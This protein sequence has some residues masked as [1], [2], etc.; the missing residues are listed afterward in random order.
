M[1]C[2]FKI[3]KSIET[4]ASGKF[5]IDDIIGPI[6]KE[7]NKYKEIDAGLVAAKLYAA[8]TYKENGTAIVKAIIAAETIEDVENA[9]ETD[10]AKKALLV[11]TVG[12]DVYKIK[13]ELLARSSVAVEKAKVDHGKIG[14]AT[15]TAE[16][17]NVR[18]N[19][20]KREQVSF[21]GKLVGVASFKI[22]R[23]GLTEGIKKSVEE[24]WSA[25][26]SAYFEGMSDIGMEFKVMVDDILADILVNYSAG[27]GF[28]TDINVAINELKALV[29]E[30][31]ETLPGNYSTS[32]TTLRKQLSDN[33]IKDKYFN[34]ILNEDF[35]FILETASG[36]ISV[37][38]EGHNAEKINTQVAGLFGEEID[39]SDVILMDFSALPKETMEELTQLGDFSEEGILE[40]TE[41]SDKD[42]NVIIGDSKKNRTFHRDSS[43]KMYYT[44]NLGATFEVSPKVFYGVN[45]TSDVNKSSM[46]PVVDSF[47]QDT[48]FLRN[49]FPMMR[50]INID[51][52][53]GRRLSYQDYQKIAP[54][55]LGRG[56]TLEE[57]TESL[58]EM[59]E[60][61]SALAGIA[62]SLHAHLFSQIPSEVNG[63][64]AFS[65]LSVGNVQNDN[66]VMAVAAA[67]TSKDQ[68]RYAFLEDGRIKVT[69]KAADQD[70]SYML[71][72]E[73][74]FALLD[75]LHTKDILAK[76]ITVTKNNIGV[77]IRGEGFFMAD[78]I[79]DRSTVAALADMFGLGTLY[80]KLD[81]QLM[82]KYDNVAKVDEEL[83][84]IF[85]GILEVAAANK[86]ATNSFIPEGRG[87]TEY[88]SKKFAKY[89]PGAILHNFKE[90]LIEALEP[91]V[92]K[93]QTIAG[94][95]MPSSSPTDRNA[96]LPKQ[97]KTY[98]R[99]NKYNNSV[100]TTFNPFIKSNLDTAIPYAEYKGA[101]IKSPMKVNGDPIKLSDW[102]Q[103][104]RVEFAMIQGSLKM[105]NKDN[106]G[107]TFFLQPIAY[108]DK[109]MIPMHEVSL[110]FD[111]FDPSPATRD[112][113]EKAWLTYNIN[114]NIDLQRISVEKMGRF[115]GANFTK[116]SEQLR[117]QPEITVSNELRI[118]ALKRAKIMMDKALLT[119]YDVAN[120]TKDINLELEKV[121]LTRQML[122]FSNADMDV[123][124]DYV[125]I[126]GK[127]VFKPHL[128][129][130]AEQL[131]RNGKK[132]VKTTL[133]DIRNEIR[134][135]GIKDS[136]VTSQL[137]SSGVSFTNTDEG[138]VNEFYDRVSMINGIYG[139]G[140]KVLTMGD[141]SYFDTRYD[142]SS[143]SEYYA[144]SDLSPKMAL[145]DTK[146]MMVKQSKRAQSNLTR[147]IVYMH[148]KTATGLKKDSAQDNII[149]F[150]Q[151]INKTEFDFKALEGKDIFEL[152]ALG[153]L[154][155][156]PDGTLMSADG[157]VMVNFG[158]D[159]VPMSKDI[160][161]NMF[162]DD[163]RNISAA[164]NTLISNAIT[165]SPKSAFYND[166][167]SISTSKHTTRGYIPRNSDSRRRWLT[168]SDIQRSDIALHKDRMVTVPDYIPSLLV[169][170]VESNVDL[171]NALG[172][173]QE[174][175]DA[176][177]F[178]HPVYE[179]LF[180]A[181][182]GGEISGFHSNKS[183]ALK[184]LTTT[185]EYGTFRQ[186]LQKKSVQN[187][188]GM[189]QLMKLGGPEVFG[190]LKKMNTAMRFTTTKMKVP[191]VDENGRVIYED[192]LD[193]FGDVIGRKPKGLVT[194]E[195]ENM[196]GLFDYFRG[197]ERGDDS[198][199][200]D[201]IS[202][203]QDYG[204]NMYNFIGMV[205]VPSNQKTGRR[206][207]N[208][209][210]D[211]FSDKEV[212][213]NIDHMANEFNF[214]VLTKQHEYDTSANAG[215]QAK[216]TLLSQ[217]VNAVGF[218]GLTNV[219]TQTLQNAME[220]MSEI[221][222][223][224]LGNVLANSAIEL[225]NE[226]GDPASYDKVIESLKKGNLS[227][228]TFNDA[229]KLA[230]KKTM[231]SGMYDMV[232]DA[233]DSDVDSAIIKQIL[234]DVEASLDT[235]LVRAKVL[236]SLR[237]GFYKDVIQIKMAGFI[238][239]VSV[240]HNVI[241]VYDIPGT[242]G[243][244]GG[245]QA[246]IQHVLDSKTP[247]EE[248]AL[249]DNTLDEMNIDLVLAHITPVDRVVVDGVSDAVA[250]R[251]G[252]A[253][254]LKAL[255]Q[256]GAQVG[257][258]KVPIKDA[259]LS[260]EKWAT[261]RG[262]DKV[263]ITL[264]GKTFTAHK[265]FVEEKIA[266]FNATAKAPITAEGL[267]LAE[268]LTKYTQDDHSLKW[269][270]ITA[271]NEV[272]EE[273]DAYKAAYRHSIATQKKRY[274][275]SEE[276]KDA[277]KKAED[278]SA[279]L[280]LETQKVAS[281]G[282][283]F[284][285][286]TPP[287]I[288]LP[289]YN[290][291][292]FGIPEGLSLHTI[293]GTD[294]HSLIHAKYYFK[295]QTDRRFKQEKKSEAKLDN[296]ITKYTRLR[297]LKM[298]TAGKQELTM[299]DDILTYL[300]SMPYSSSDVVDVNTGPINK[301]IDA[302]H[303]IAMTRKAEAF[304]ASLSTTLTRIPGQTKQSG[305]VG[306]VV[307]FLD[308]QGNATFA[309]TE[310][311]VNTGGDF[312]IDTLSVLTKMI[313][314]NGDMFDYSQFTDDK[315]ILS[316]K[317]VTSAYLDELKYIEKKAEDSAAEYNEKLNA[318]IGQLKQR[319]N[320]L[321]IA[322]KKGVSTAKG[323]PS[324]ADIEAKRNQ[325]EEELLA[326]QDNEIMPKE[327]EEITTKA[328]KNAY[329]R[330]MN[331]LSNAM[332]DGISTS[333]S[334]LDTAVEAQTPISMDMFAGLK[335][336]IQEMTEGDTSEMDKFKHATY[337]I[338]GESF[339]SH[340]VIED[341]AAQG[342]EAIGIYATVLK[343]NS[344][345]QTSKY[346]FDSSTQVKTINP[347]VWKT[348]ITFDSK[349]HGEQKTY[350]RTGF[351]DLDRFK[352]ATAVASDE[353][354]QNVLR[355]L[356]TSDNIYD[357]EAVAIMENMLLQEVN[358]TI[359]ALKDNGETLTPED[360][361][362]I[363]RSQI[364]NTFGIDIEQEV[365]GADSYAVSGKALA[366]EFDLC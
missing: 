265:W 328:K 361:D 105:M 158:D 230:F 288:V 145:N 204:E 129:V 81:T 236:G 108:S 351:A 293:I 55:L 275:T 111:A 209:W 185:F 283:K 96:T 251:Y 4:V 118:E 12:S 133:K 285:K 17:V 58:K 46:D 240:I 208:S 19:K 266:E 214:E 250:A 136:D 173:N 344:A 356:A 41:D 273:S 322:I 338:N 336:A 49:I 223:I 267:I 124:V 343:M 117:S 66:I 166:A 123:D 222:S 83:A 229:E 161:N 150:V 255:I 7:L 2:K 52:T 76:N 225:M 298:K 62:R 34:D 138:N 143:I 135:M 277:T 127:A 316:T 13:D 290:A 30:R 300:Y 194:L 75:G 224:K 137:S 63:M 247:L 42:A 97:I 280:M 134:R 196:Q 270:K 156:F 310:H 331:V 82:A 296:L 162:N 128:G 10:T 304:V 142:Q 205:S 276:Y 152:E 198:A 264:A 203:L 274:A 35:D 348:Q 303:D 177:Q 122:M 172:V 354:I 149:N 212:E 44:N 362:A 11:D 65:L 115:I 291:K 232:V 103:K 67:L 178:M 360:K 202:V 269:Y 114:K 54:R 257:I 345:V 259:T 57:L 330:M 21:D 179:L 190:M 263:T 9:I 220:S 249:L 47:S 221:D 301:I 132:I 359:R 238:G 282:N 199:W 321:D 246:F 350:M 181:A 90:E 217:L 197:Y 106:I 287:E 89:P 327:I 363:V 168:V 211:V 167:N 15:E 334:K 77:E 184:T 50:M 23:E 5:S 40:I 193:V 31:V 86:K 262:A 261:L 146:D 171:L 329:T 272:I 43:G 215:H 151:I 307:E 100:T 61:T 311:L 130:R 295:K 154:S 318:R 320:K 107:K 93:G 289:T 355:D 180:K 157:T 24:Q 207:L 281:D 125:F 324:M 278:L 317:K 14:T 284:W 183:N 91:D 48:D 312:D 51:G 254:G 16:I 191:M 126:G 335:K 73:L 353:R 110:D 139:H 140:L 121:G 92:T 169:S 87:D 294:G 342:K 244:R 28:S 104:I 226:S 102:T 174:N 243:K 337:D 74:S 256:G 165:I 299:Y 99:F 170:D 33:D 1:K 325:Y 319:I 349:Y 253:E 340:F 176:V 69:R 248:L 155:R 314:A 357:P 313:G 206:K 364:I 268:K 309:P 64:A 38:Q 36:M 358:D 187:V 286:I 189:E 228:T 160:E 45:T 32:G 80:R 98:D 109:S 113:L 84:D 235:P 159:M 186:Q 239:T 292:A 147:G 18:I 25:F 116:L 112:K 323:M 195:A 95:K 85:G 78:E 29:K 341:L 3:R 164:I 26:L 213:L 210:D 188:F 8:A 346:K 352:I 216:L 227:S 237:S 70:F 56:N 79:A 326:V 182:R 305:F 68:M 144:Q 175:S 22:K 53:Y 200:T 308:A 163:H 219:E 88:K 59:G 39:S 315:G 231:Q 119:G 252:G 20:K 71:D 101:V 218:G 302:A 347:Y 120:I 260:A 148:K 306:T 245:R 333:L 339:L 60:E 192:E 258:V 297:I 6:S 94:S 72:D 153:V 141:E 366:A 233:F 201:V 27:T 271:G 279:A 332:E 241:N 131:A 242:L 37:E 365:R 234:E